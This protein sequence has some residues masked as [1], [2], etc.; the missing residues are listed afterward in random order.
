MKLKTTALVSLTIMT[1]LVLG[2]AA[3]EIHHRVRFGQFA[4]YGVHAD[5]VEDRSDLDIPGIRTVYAARVTDFTLF[6]LVLVGFE[7]AGDSPPPMFYCRYQVQ[8]LSPRD[9]DWI[10]LFD[11]NPV[12]DEHFSASHKKLYPFRSLVP[13]QTYAIGARDDVQKGDLVRFAIFTNLYAGEPD[14][15]TEPF[16]ISEVR[17]TASPPAR[18]AQ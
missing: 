11:F 3:I 17:A 16:R 5:V 18:S 7:D 10:V 9:G 1:V 14:V 12:K 8:K 6:P 2:V 13:M 4:S 15:Y